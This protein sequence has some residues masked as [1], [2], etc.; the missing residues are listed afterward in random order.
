MKKI[1]YLC[2]FFPF[3]YGQESPYKKFQTYMNEKDGRILNIHISQEQ[4][5]E[6]FNSTGILYYFENKEYVFDTYRE[7]IA[8]KDGTIT[9]IN[10]ATKQIIYDMDVANNLTVL[11]ILSGKDDRV[12][13]A[14]PILEKD[15][16]RIP[17]ILSEWDIKGD[18]W[19]VPTTGKPKK[20]ILN[21]SVDEIITLKI[22]TAEIASK[23]IIPQID[24]IEYEI[25]DLRE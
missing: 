3:L 14:D 16:F 15:S 1:I 9:T 2:F 12:I 24:T 23:N 11:D 20:I 10:K 21:I 19:T 5:G 6:H 13:V 18:I 17:F 25:I 22:I 7:R 4:L 8:Y